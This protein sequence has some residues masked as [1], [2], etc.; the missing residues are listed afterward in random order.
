MYGR[1]PIALPL[2]E[3]LE[4]QSIPEPNSGCRLWIGTYAKLSSGFC[5]G[6]I[7]VASGKGQRLAHRMMWEV[8]NGPIPRG[9]CVCHK[10]DV[11]E[12][13]EITHLF[14]G[15]HQDNMDDMKAKNRHYR[16]P[17]RRGVDNE[18]AKLTDD[19]VRAIRKDCR[20]LRVIAAEYGVHLS[21]IWLVQ[22]GRIWKHVK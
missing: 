17:A 16:I 21:L 10:C 15:T 14:L 11:P 3:R 2:R 7:T 18:K 1:V 19:Q 20:I 4:L 13:V 22:N 8:H 5:Y 9:L 12:C 6:L